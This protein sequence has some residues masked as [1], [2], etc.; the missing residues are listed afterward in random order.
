MN[1]MDV[2]MMYLS[3]GILAYL[4][5][6]TTM[7]LTSFLATIVALLLVFG[8]NLIQYAAGWVRIAMRP[9]RRGHTLPGMHAR[10]GRPR[11]GQDSPG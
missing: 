8:K 10:T 7:P 1:C 3:S 5:P 9:R 2:N 11:R 6:E 4:G